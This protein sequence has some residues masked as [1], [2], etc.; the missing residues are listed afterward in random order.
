M[1]KNSFWW[2]AKKPFR[3]VAPGKESR[4]SKIE[5]RLDFSLYVQLYC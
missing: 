4:G 1:H 5:G 3:V 2:Y